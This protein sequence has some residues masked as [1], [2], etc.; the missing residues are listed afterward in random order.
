MYTHLLIHT[1]N[2]LNI[3]NIANTLTLIQGLK[4]NR[5]PANNLLMRKIAITK[6]IYPWSY[7]TFFT[8]LWTTM[9]RIIASIN[10]QKLK[11]STQVSELI[12]IEIFLLLQEISISSHDMIV[13]SN[14]ENSKK[15]QIFYEKKWNTV[16]KKTEFMHEITA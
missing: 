11:E 7:L 5:N 12:E 8:H 14:R 9:I 15:M 2:D 4:S 3:S 1:F 13:A 10:D 16:Q 6:H